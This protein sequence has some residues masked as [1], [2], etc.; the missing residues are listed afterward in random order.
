MGAGELVLGPCEA[1]RRDEGERRET[2]VDHGDDAAVVIEVRHAEVVAEPVLER[3]LGI[4]RIRR[5]VAVGEHCQL[6]QL[7]Q[8][9]GEV[10][11]RHEGDPFGYDQWR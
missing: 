11:E 8:A 2:I 4:E 3:L 10:D 7:A 6:V 9:L 1:V 5:V